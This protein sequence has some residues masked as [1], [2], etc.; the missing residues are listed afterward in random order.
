MTSF[1][2]LSLYSLTVKQPTATQDAIPGDFVGTGKQQILT[3]NGSR[4]TLLE[5]SRRQNGFQEL[6]SQDVFGIIRHVAKFRLAGATKGMSNS[7]PTARSYLVIFRKHQQRQARA[8]KP[9][10]V[11]ASGWPD[12]PLKDKNV[13]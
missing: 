10:R 2:T 5:V 4:L 7:L 3:A 8:R 11:G 1:S 6:Y 9:R 12:E 13:C